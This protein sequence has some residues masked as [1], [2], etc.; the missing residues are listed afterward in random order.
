MGE[1]NVNYSYPDNPD[2]DYVAM[3]ERLN[4]DEEKSNDLYRG[5][6]FIVSSPKKSI[7]KDIKDPDGIFSTKFG[8][9]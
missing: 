4:L 6:G 2:F 1:I 9:K 7:K 3:M 5:K 8:Q